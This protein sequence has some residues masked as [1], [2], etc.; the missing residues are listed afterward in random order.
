MSYVTSI[1]LIPKVKSPSHMSD[2]MP[3]SCCSVIYKCITKFLSEKLRLVLPHLVSETQGAFVFGRSIL[4]NILL[5]QD[6][7]KMYKSSQKQKCCM[8]KI[9]M[10]KAYY[11]VCWEF[12]EDMMKALQFPPRFIH[13]VMTCVCSPT[14]TLMINGST[15]GFFRSQRGLR[16]ED[17]MPPILFVL[18]ME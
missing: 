2:Y 11:S 18:F 12:L 8:M 14:F 4:H 1:T 13:F 17:S 10:H 15:T 6:I 16:Q 7:I 3:I 5:C 9:D